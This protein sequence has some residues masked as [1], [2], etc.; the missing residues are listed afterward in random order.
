MSAAPKLAATWCAWCG[1]QVSQ[2]SAVVTE[3]HKLARAHVIACAE[4]PLNQLLTAGDALLAA[5]EA[6]DGA[7]T[8]DL[9]E[10]LVAFRAA[11][12]DARGAA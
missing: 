12:V 6:P 8:S 10:A 7:E 2:E 3:R 1:E 11:L 4:H 9:A 5:A